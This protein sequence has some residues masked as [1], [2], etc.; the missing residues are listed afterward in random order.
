MPELPEAETIV[1]GLRRR[2]AGRCIAEVHL[3]RSD[4]IHGDPVPLCAALHNRCIRDI[5]R[6]GKQIRLMLDGGRK[7]AIHLGMS[8][9]LIAAQHDAPLAPHT[10]LRFA[11]KRTRYEIRF[12]DP[13]R[14]GGIWLIG[15]DTNDHWI[16]KALP[17]VGLDALQIS[18]IDL[19]RVLQH[20]RQIKPLL[21]DQHL[22][23][24]IGNIYCDEILHRA[25][26]HPLTRANELDA[27]ARRR[28]SRAMRQVLRAA[29]AA[30][31]SSISDYRT[32]D[33]QPGS[34]QQQHR[35]YDRAKLPCTTCG[36]PIERLVVAVR[37]TFICPRCQPETWP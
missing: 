35:V 18:R 20:R 19:D 30:G 4:V 7:L 23:A 22:I 36:T 25:R 1:Q 34:F 21:L 5:G 31:G 12:I 28:L 29:I 3:S 10:H 33:D 32:V 24:G 37:G 27:D 14:F 2:I 15:P 16:G 17:E 6:V 8:G 11:M 9:K 26:I 13:R